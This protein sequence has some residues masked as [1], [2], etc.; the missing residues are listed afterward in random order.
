MIWYTQP[1]RQEFMLRLMS[2]AG[3][4]HQTGNTQLLIR[5]IDEAED[6]VDPESC[7][8]GSVGS[9][10]GTLQKSLTWNDMAHDPFAP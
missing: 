10:E 7:A 3:Q 1:N 6:D 4:W 5:E 2:C 8:P 9:W